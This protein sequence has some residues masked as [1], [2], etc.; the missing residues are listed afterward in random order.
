MI[1]YFKKVKF[2]LRPIY[3]EFK[4]EVFYEECDEK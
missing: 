2:V 3:V 1:L 4:M